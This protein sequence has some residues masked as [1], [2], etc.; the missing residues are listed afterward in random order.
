MV[1]MTTDVLELQMGSVARHVT[2]CSEHQRSMVRVLRGSATLAAHGWDSVAP[3]PTRPTVD[4]AA[5]LDPIERAFTDA[6]KV[7]MP[8]VIPTP[9]GRSDPFLEFFAPSMRAPSG[10]FDDFIAAASTSTA[11]RPR[12]VGPLPP[13]SRFMMR[14]ATVDRPH[15]ATKRNYDYFEELKAALADLADNE[16]T[17]PPSSRS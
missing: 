4:I 10:P 16:G 17:K 13:R 2:M 12:P 1:G 5:I 8:E 14:V 15:R 7:E 9:P 11:G 3:G 6:A